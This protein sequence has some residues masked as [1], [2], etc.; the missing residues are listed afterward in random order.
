MEIPL[1]LGLWGSHLID[2]PAQKC[3]PDFVLVQLLEKL[4]M[5]SPVRIIGGLNPKKPQ[6]VGEVPIGL[7]FL[8]FPIPGPRIIKPVRDTLDEAA[9]FPGSRLCTMSSPASS[10]RVPYPSASSKYKGLHLSASK[11]KSLFCSR[12]KNLQHNRLTSFRIASILFPKSFFEL[13]LVKRNRL[14]GIVPKI[15]EI[16]EVIEI[17]IGAGLSPKIGVNGMLSNEANV[18]LEE[19]SKLE[20]K[21]LDGTLIIILWPSNPQANALARFKKI[22]RITTT[23]TLFRRGLAREESSSKSISTLSS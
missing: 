7:G 3:R 17:R 23:V 8:H 6:K 12:I 5:H 4:G 9:W 19:T 13:L 20:R 1:Y 22:G 16:E 10:P 18:V 21:D 2:L 14:K 15:I 11:T